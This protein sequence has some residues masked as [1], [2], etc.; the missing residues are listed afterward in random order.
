MERPSEE[1]VE[2]TMQATLA[3]L[4]KVVTN[5]I[6]VANP[7]SLPT[8]TQPGAPT[9]IKYTPS[10]QGAE[11]RRLAISPPLAQADRHVSP[12]CSMHQGRSSAS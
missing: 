1:E 7:K 6:Q 5:K 8:G 12:F 10:Q 2:A 11:V 4:S 3:A 9:Y